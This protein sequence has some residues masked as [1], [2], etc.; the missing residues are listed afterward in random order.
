MM[1]YAIGGAI[2]FGILMMIAKNKAQ[3]GAAWAAPVQIVC[4]LLAIG[5][6]IWACFE[7]VAGKSGTLVTAEKWQ[8]VRGT[9][10]ALKLQ[11]KCKDQKLLIVKSASVPGQAEVQFNAIKKGLDGM[12][13]E[14]YEIPLPDENDMSSE[15]MMMMAEGQ[16]PSKQMLAE[17]KKMATETESAISGKASP[18]KY[19]VVV[20]LASLPDFLIY[21]MYGMQPINSMKDKKYVFLYGI[22]P[23]R[24]KEKNLV[25]YM[26]DK[27]LANPDDYDKP[28]QGNQSADFSARFEFIDGPAK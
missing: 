11:E 16:K 20:F 13:Y 17:M 23:R 4:A 12:T 6:A 1:M 9:G 8:E 5:C 14:V 27:A 2:V 21:P 15:M 22:D 10:I 28:P 7:Q 24:K 19:D 3:T 26:S 18:D 25:G